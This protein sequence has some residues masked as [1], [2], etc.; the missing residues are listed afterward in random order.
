MSVLLLAITDRLVSGQS[1]SI[2][3]SMLLVFLLTALMF[4]SFTLGFFNALPLIG[5]I[6]INFGIMGLA[7]LYLNEITIS[8]SSVAIGVGVDYGIHFVHRVRHK[9]ATTDS[10]EDAIRAAF[11]DS[12]VA[13]W[14]NAITVALGFATLMAASFRGIIVMG[15]LL[16]LTMLASAFCALTVLPVLF[17]IF[18]PRTLKKT[19]R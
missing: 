3:V 14:F 1:L 17:A 6:V 4:R 18:K 12:G 9:L 2:G 8:V 10:Y 7:N 15:F 5:T 11:R 16:S 19:A 13:I